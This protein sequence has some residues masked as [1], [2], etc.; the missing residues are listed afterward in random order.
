MNSKV[1][2]ITWINSDRLT[3]S[4]YVLHFPL[5]NYKVLKSCYSTTSDI[6]FHLLVPRFCVFCGS[7]IALNENIGKLWYIYSSYLLILIFTL[8]SVGYNN[9]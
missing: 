9:F 3:F 5:G 7:S 4:F 1:S 2:V 6:I 8:A